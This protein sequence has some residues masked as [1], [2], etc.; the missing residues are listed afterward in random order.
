MVPAGN[1]AKRLS[2]VNR[3]TK[4]I[5]DHRH[6]HQATRYLYTMIKILASYYGSHTV[7]LVHSC[8]GWKKVNKEALP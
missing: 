1:K 3:T 5:H 4:T 2:S 6:H 7:T 8:Y